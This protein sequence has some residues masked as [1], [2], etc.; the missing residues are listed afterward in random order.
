LI[1]SVRGTPDDETKKQISNEYALKYI[2][3][4][5]VKEKVPL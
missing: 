3:S 5:A 1:I 2:E 4:L